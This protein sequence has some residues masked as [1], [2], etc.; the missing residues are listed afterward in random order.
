MGYRPGG[1]G[2]PGERAQGRCQDRRCV[3][4]KP[5]LAEENSVKTV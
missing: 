5:L 2:V 4:Q 1:G 3:V